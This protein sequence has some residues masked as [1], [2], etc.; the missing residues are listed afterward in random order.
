MIFYRFFE[1]TLPVCIFEFL[2]KLL[3]QY[4]SH[5]CFHDFASKLFLDMSGFYTDALDMTRGVQR[6]C[7]Q[8][9]TSL[10]A[11]SWFAES[12][13]SPTAVCYRNTGIPPEI[14]G[15]QFSKPTYK[16]WCMLRGFSSSGDQ[17]K[18]SSF[19][20]LHHFH[21]VIEAKPLHSGGHKGGF[22]V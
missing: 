6:N 20:V 5:H 7:Y 17:T 18:F 10:A 14:F 8:D 4:Q 22:G 2:Q 12:F 11:V 13:P 19:P 16:K 1:T 15:W 21:E 9:G 3:F